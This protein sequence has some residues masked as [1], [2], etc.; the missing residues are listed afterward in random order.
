MST[1]VTPEWLSA[2]RAVEHVR[3]KGFDG[4]TVESLKYYAYRT[5]LLPKPTVVGRHAYWRTADLDALVQ[6]L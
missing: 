6:Q 5:E 3:D 1:T 2:E 4:F